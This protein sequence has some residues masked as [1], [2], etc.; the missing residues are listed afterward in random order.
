M[1]AAKTPVRTDSWIAMSWNEYLDHLEEPACR[2]ARTFYYQGHGRFEMRPIGFGHGRNHAVVNYVVTLFCALTAVPLQ[3]A[4]KTALRKSGVTESRPDLSIWTG[5]KVKEISAETEIIDLNR[6]PVPDLIVE[7]ADAFSLIDDIGVKRS[8]YESLGVA[9]YWIVDV[10]KG[11]VTAF[12]MKQ[13]GS[14]RVETSQILPN[15]DLS[16]LGEAL[17]LSRETDQAQMG[18]WL[19]QQ[20]QQ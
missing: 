11:T 1:M 13:V 18:V 2:N 16:M 20:F 19:L 6:Y 10:K 3:M 15:F 5:D 9:E 14:W 8:L 7:V 4:S 17:R 12:E